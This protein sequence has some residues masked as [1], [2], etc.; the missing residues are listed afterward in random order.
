MSPAAG[1]LHPDR[2]AG[3]DHHHR[4]G[5][6]G[7]VA[8]RA[9]GPEPSP[10][11]RGGPDPP[12]RAWSVPATRPSA[13]TP[14]AASASCPTRLQ[15]PGAEHRSWRTTGSSPSR[16]P[17][18]TPPAGSR[19]LSGAGRISRRYL[20]GA[21]SGRGNRASGT[22]DVDETP[23][24]PD[25]GI[26]NE[27]TSW[28]WNIRV[29][30]KI[31]FNDAGRLLHGR[32]AAMNTSH[33]Q[34]GRRTPSC[35][36]TSGRPVDL[37]SGPVSSSV[38]ELQPYS[39]NPEFL[40]LVNGQTTTSDGF[41]D[42]AGTGSIITIIGHRQT[43]WR[44]G[45]RRD[46]LRSEQWVGAE[47]SRNAAAARRRCS[48]TSR[49]RSLRRPVAVPGAREVTLPGGVVIDADDLERRPRSGRGCRSTR[50]PLYV[51]ILVNP[52]ARSCRPRRTRAPR[53]RPASPFYHFWLTERQDVHEPTELWGVDRPTRTRRYRP[54]RCPSGYAELPSVRPI[55]SRPR[56]RRSS[57]KGDRAAGDA[58]RAAPGRSRA[59]R[60]R[61]ST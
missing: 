40:F 16:R 39:S 27:R 41:I 26:P 48:S 51:D 58:V 55:R 22:A 34:H 8:D 50:R 15:R 36:S 45:V 46:E 61:T 3:G 30:D 21:E 53:R 28:F 60:S 20:E 10:G 23:I 47:T 12:G 1:Q 13:T 6:R 18:T 5:Q 54:A 14:P 37:A 31:R 49:T 42:R 4:P 29:G 35:S 25:N 9:A 17:P 44:A 19:S 59:T 56:R 32:R 33:H 43:T 38:P 52:T 11:G 24:E 7:D 57:L 2:A